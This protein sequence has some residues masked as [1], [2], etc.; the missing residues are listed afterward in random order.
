MCKID[1][2]KK[3]QELINYGIGSGAY[4]VTE[5]KTLD[6]LKVLYRASYTEISKSMSIVQKDYLNQTNLDN[7]MAKQKHIHLIRLMI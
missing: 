3:L 1:Y 6:G 5:D 4:K 2:H 7:S